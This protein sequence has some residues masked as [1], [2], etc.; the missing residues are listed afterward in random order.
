MLK[1]QKRIF[2]VKQYW[3]NLLWSFFCLNI[4]NTHAFSTVPL[5]VYLSCSFINYVIF[6]ILRK[7]HFLCSFFQTFRARFRMLMDHS[8]NTLEEDATTFTASLDRTEIALFNLGNK[9][10]IDVKNWHNRKNQKIATADLVVNLKK[11]KRAIMEESPWSFI[12]FI[13]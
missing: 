13:C 11:R 1:W 6:F 8:Q 4:C 7:L 10:L 3:Y 9:S 5:S 12:L 2:N